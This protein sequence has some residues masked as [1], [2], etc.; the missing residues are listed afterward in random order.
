MLFL[1]IFTLFQ[2]T[3]P[4]SL[5]EKCEMSHCHRLDI[6]NKVKYRREKNMQILVLLPRSN[7]LNT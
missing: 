7:H 6:N 5:R 2:L 1:F 4:I 3:F